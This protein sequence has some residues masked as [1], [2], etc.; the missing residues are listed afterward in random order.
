MRTRP[1]SILALVAALVLSACSSTTVV[2][3]DERAAGEPQQDAVAGTGGGSDGDDTVASDDDGD[4]DDSGDGD[5]DA[6]ESNED[7]SN[8]EAA[9]GDEDTDGADSPDDDDSGD[10][11]SD[12]DDGDGDEFDLGDGEGFGLGGSAQV[13][14]L[15]ADCED[16]SDLACDVLF[17]ISAFNSPEEEAAVTCGGRSDTEVT[18]CADGVQAL[19]DQLVF[20]PDSEGIE[21]IVELCQDD[22][23]MTACDF[24]YY[25]SPLESEFEEIGT[26]CGGRV[27]VAV[28]DCRTLLAG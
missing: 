18:F 15:L 2:S 21:S 10:D 19:P 23:D 8:D 1:W 28:P 3:R 27:S 11:G 26:T 7:D 14:S 22:G 17:Q 5:P 6:D 13:D 12:G 24:L 25:R 16:G 4:G 9:T 20:D